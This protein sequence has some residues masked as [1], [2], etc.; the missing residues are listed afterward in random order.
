MAVLPGFSVPTNE[1]LAL[2][3]RLRRPLPE[4]VFDVQMQ[5]HR[6]LVA[7]DKVSEMARGIIHKPKS[8]VDEEQRS[9]GSG[10]IVSVGPL[11]GQDGAPHPVGIVCDNPY[12]LLGKH[13]YYGMHAGKVFRTDDDDEEYG[14][15]VHLIILTDRDIQGIDDGGPVPQDLT[16]AEQL[17][18]TKAAIEQGL[19]EGQQLRVEL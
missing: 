3:R 12:D 9:S 17:A 19:D 10:Y 8:T 1:R 18:I 7:Q 5:G 16:E 11:C 14:G 6:L 4:A 15:K 2:Y 13:V